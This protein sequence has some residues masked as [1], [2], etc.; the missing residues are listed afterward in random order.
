MDKD[1]IW[2][3]VTVGLFLFIIFIFAY[4]HGACGNCFDRIVF[5]KRKEKKC[6]ESE[7]MDII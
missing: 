3:L 2:G 7:N 4:N 1:K 5:N 6:S